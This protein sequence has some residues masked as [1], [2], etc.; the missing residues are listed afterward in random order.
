MPETHTY[1]LKVSCKLSGY[2]FV[3]ASNKEEA[4]K[5]VQA[6]IEEDAGVQLVDEEYSDY[7]VSTNINELKQQEKLQCFYPIKKYMI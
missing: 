7:E 6:A 3:E 2:T 1:F 5:K 4:Y